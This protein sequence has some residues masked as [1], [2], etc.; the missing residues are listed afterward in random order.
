MTTLVL[1]K[2]DMELLAFLARHR[3]CDLE[4]IAE[5]FFARDPFSGAPNKKRTKACARRI[6]RLRAH[7]Y[8][9]LAR[10]KDGA[11]TRSVAH[12]AP[13]SG[14]P[15]EDGDAPHRTLG[16]KNRIHHLRTLDA[17]RLL[18]IDIKAR[19]GRV[20][21]FETESLLRA[22]TQRGRRTRPGDSFASFPDAVCTVVLPTVS[23]ERQVN[24]ALEIVTIKYTSADIREKHWSF[25]QH[26]AEAVW[27]ADKASTSA[28][29]QHIT[30]A[31]CLTLS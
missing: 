20:V 17:L 3:E 25:G 29:V 22:K 31:P 30:G 4:L 7:G 2:R 10:V 9:G 19:G 18:E 27:F 16:P 21:S 24:I 13:R 11:K 5:L 14:Q 6:S 8:V 15:L 26:Y 1:T 23:G 12:L 28:R